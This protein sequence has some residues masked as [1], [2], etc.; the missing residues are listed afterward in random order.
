[1]EKSNLRGRILKELHGLISQS[2]SNEAASG[3]FRKL[4]EL[5]VKKYYN[6]TDVV[7][8]YHR[9][10]VQIDVVL[11]EAAYDPTK[12]NT[13]IP[14][15]RANLLFKNIGEFLSS[16]IETDRNSLAFYAWLLRTFSKKD[17]ELSVV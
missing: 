13:H 14:T 11:D 1:M 7:I 9:K 6:A 16:C 2:C 4:H 8:D 12:V 17:I 3:T 10:R 5:I 15:F